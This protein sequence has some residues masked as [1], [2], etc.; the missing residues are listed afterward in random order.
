MTPS[1][2]ADPLRVSPEGAEYAVAEIAWSPDGRAVAYRAQVDGGVERL[3][4]ADV[5]AGTA[6][7]GVYAVFGFFMVVL[8]PTTALL[9]M[10]RDGRASELERAL[11][12]DPQDL[13]VLHNAGCGLVAAGEIDRALDLFEERF[14]KGDVYLPWIENDSD[15]D[16]LREHPRFKA[17][18]RKS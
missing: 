5:A 9:A 13:G 18:L 7:T 15:F 17:M 6:L 3:F 4:L 8:W 2:R 11:E 12:I 1:N 10:Q 16:P 14:A